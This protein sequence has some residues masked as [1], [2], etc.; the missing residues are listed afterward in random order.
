MQPP[1]LSNSERRAAKLLQESPDPL[2]A[3]RK[4]GVYGTAVVAQ[5]QVRSEAG[6]LE[7]I[8]QLWRHRGKRL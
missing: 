8:L 3:E 7:I 6:D 4:D 1:T 5:S 2:V